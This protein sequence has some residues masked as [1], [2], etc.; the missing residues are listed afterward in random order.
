MNLQDN[1]FDE[2]LKLAITSRDAGVLTQLMANPSSKIR[3]AVA[4]NESSPSTVLKILAFDPVLNVSFKA[5]ENPNCNVKRCLSGVD[6]P[7][8]CCNIPEDKKDCKS[9]CKAGVFV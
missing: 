7:C 2:N 1:S 3:R 8:V 6:H 9:V 4:R 5:L